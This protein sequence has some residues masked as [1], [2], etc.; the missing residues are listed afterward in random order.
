VGSGLCGISLVSFCYSRVAYFVALVNCG[1]LYCIC[2]L[3]WVWCGVM[4]SR[5]KRVQSNFLRV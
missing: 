3:W 5:G 1:R 4:L 2:R